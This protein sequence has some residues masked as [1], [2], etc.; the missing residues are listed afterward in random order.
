MGLTKRRIQVPSTLIYYVSASL[1]GYIARPDG[2]VDWLEGYGSEADDHGY[3][4]FYAGIDG[5]LMGRATYLFCLKQ[6]QWPYPDKPALVMT[7]SN[8]LSKAAPQVEL[9]HYAPVD[10]IA[11]LEARG[12]ERIWLVGGGSLAGNFLAGGL[13]DEVIVSII[14]HLLGAGIPL[15]SIGL[16]QRL[17]LLEQR[18]FPSGIVQMRYQVLKETPSP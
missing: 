3:N 14:P 9:E 6:E 12:C 18:S 17:Q 15:F 5:L 8:H 1:D 10:A 11:S 2:S 7:R 4:A 16:E 13:L